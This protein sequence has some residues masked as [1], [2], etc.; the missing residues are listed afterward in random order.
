MPYT[1]T[2]WN[3]GAAPAINASNL[4]KIEQGIYDAQNTA[5]SAST[6]ATSALSTAN[7][8]NIASKIYQYKNLGGG[9]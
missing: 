5:D 2:T 4:N 1:K 6:S 8:A 9:L 3:S 7:S